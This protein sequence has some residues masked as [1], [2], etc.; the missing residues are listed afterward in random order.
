[1]KNLN[2]FNIYLFGQTV[3]YSASLSLNVPC[4]PLRDEEPPQFYVVPHFCYISDIS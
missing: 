2:D 4:D 1:M 3:Y